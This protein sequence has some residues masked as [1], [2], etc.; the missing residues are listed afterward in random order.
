M[1]L[2]QR[3]SGGAKFQ[4]ELGLKLIIPVAV[5]CALALA[6]T[7]AHADPLGIHFAGTGNGQTVTV[8]YNNSNDTTFAGELEWTFD[9]P[10]PAGWD[11]TFYSYCVDLTQDANWSQDVTLASTTAMDNG[12][13][14]VAWL[15]NTYA[16]GIHTTN[17][18]ADEKAAGLQL[19]IWET[20]YD[21]GFNLSSGSFRVT[22]ASVWA[23]KYANDYLEGLQ[24]YS[25]A[26]VE[27]TWL[28]TSRGQDQVSVNP[29]PEPGTLLL[30]GSGVAAFA[31]RRRVRRAA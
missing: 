13:S 30:L 16:A 3:H 21:P 17:F 19:A 6:P 12:G 26:M 2:A 10:P 9:G 1:R 11:S 5:L 18:R 23:L 15:I 14:D 20:L 25:G 27:A 31:A 22:D 7:A 8:K 24:K 28:D 4:R 29:V